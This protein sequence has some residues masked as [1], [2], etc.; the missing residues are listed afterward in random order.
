MNILICDDNRNDAEEFASL[1]RASGFDV[2]TVIFDSGRNALDH[3]RSGAKVDVYFLDIVMP[4]MSGVA[5]AEKLRED[6]F[7]GEIIFLTISNE[8][9]AESYVVDAFSYLLKPAALDRVRDILCKLEE[10]RR[11]TG[12]EDGILVKIGGQVRLIPFHDISYIEA[13]LNKVLFR[14]TDGFEVESYATFREIAGQ[15]L[16]DKRFV[17]CHRSFIVNMSNIAVISGKKIT[18]RG[19]KII[20][21]SRSYPGVKKRFAQWIIRIEK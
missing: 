16:N 7:G 12:A 15:L 17:Q 21:I 20:P 11:K 19:G 6:G 2:N 14:L 4:E 18:L 9:A 13:M 3:V 8:Y 1:I 10:K 5:L